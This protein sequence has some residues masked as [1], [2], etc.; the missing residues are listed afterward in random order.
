MTQR[1]WFRSYGDVPPHIN[2][3]AYSSIVALLELAMGKYADKTAF[4]SFGQS[5]TYR[6]ID[7]LSARFASYLQRELGV[8][9]GDRIAVMMP[10]LVAFPLVFIGIARLGAVQVNVNPLYT[11]RE[12]AHQLNDAG[13]KTIVAF[14]GSTPTL[15]EV[16]KDTGVTTV[17]T[18][19][20]GDGLPQPVPAPAADARL[21]GV[22]P[23]ADILLEGK[24]TDYR[25]PALTG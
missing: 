12:L 16:I 25:V 15:A 14:N 4:R 1:P 18:A 7:R 23:L 20:P 11:A 10:N 17:I 9:K 3:D 2:P 21:S 24:P 22:V 5:L 13:V 6:D 8:A 19:G